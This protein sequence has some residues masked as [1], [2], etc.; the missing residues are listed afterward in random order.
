M[1]PK[2]YLIFHLNLCFSSIE[3]EAWPDV[4]QKCYS[5]LLELI[6]RTGV[7]IG[8]ELTGWTLKQ[9]EKIDPAWIVRFK[10]LLEA[11][12][13]ELIGSG[14]SQI[15]SPLIPYAVNDWNQKL[16][17][18]IYEQILGLRPNIILVNEM[19]Y[20][21]NLVELYAQH[22]YDGFI[23]DRDNVRLALGIEELPISEVPTHAKGVDNNVLPVLWA[24]SILF[25]KVQHYAHGDIAIFDYLD[26]LKKRISNNET[27]LPIY[28]NDAEV[29]D[30]RPGRFSEERPTHAEGEWRRVERLIKAI[31]TEIGME[32]VSP[33]QALKIND[34]SSNR[35]VSKLNSG[36]HPIP[37]KKQAKYNIARWAVTGRDDL[38]LNTM[39]YRIA[40]HLCD[41]KNQN[42]QDW[43]D[44]CELWA[45]DLRT[46]IT[47]KRWQN[48][49]KQV[50]KFLKRHN[51]RESFGYS[52][53]QSQPNSYSSLESALGQYQDFKITLDMDDTL[54]R[55]ATT[56]LQI[57][58]NMRR[59]LTINS[60]AFDTHGLEPCIGTLPHGYFSSIKFG[61]DYYSGGVVIDTPKE[62]SRITD[63]DAV[64]PY[65]L[66]NDKREL[67]VYVT[68]STSMGNIEKV[69]RVSSEKEH[70][71][72]S[73][74]FPDWVRAIGSVRLG[75][76]TFLPEIYDENINVDC[77][78]DVGNHEIFTMDSTASHHMPSSALVSSSG[79]LGATVGSICVEGVKN[80]VQ[81]QWNTDDCAVM[82][83]FQH[84]PIGEKSLSRIFFS[85]LEVD[86]TSKKSS[87]LGS[88]SFS[89]SP[90]K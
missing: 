80:G 27:L 44:L 2:G 18:R 55:I 17:L 8:I 30:F 78:D 32:W 87:K 41:S 90:S 84:D 15:I 35:K 16:G 22:G 20:S 40:K 59:G 62:R 39:C 36:M 66:L 14:Y 76:I 48:T 23:M 86:D 11:G 56:K 88:F 83:M 13:C 74:H 49:K 85:M 7:P 46:H 10:V 53:I 77:I 89:I 60:L 64:V 33:S 70:I 47:E 1:S 69:I 6:E 68:I 50:S 71:E 24:D 34:Q 73:Y 21:S 19:A 58:L 5:P 28:C 42:P 65:F 51:I 82:P 81:L 29:F 9:I 54:L 25:Q 3:E 52:D 43:C 57:E 37:V 63:L 67:E 26:Y 75:N 61:A 79:G 72:L 45:S 38:W 4:I 31:D 12:H